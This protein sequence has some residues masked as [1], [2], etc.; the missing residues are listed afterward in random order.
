[1][2]RFLLSC[3][4][5]F[6]ASCLV[7]VICDKSN[8]IKPSYC[9]FN[10]AQDALDSLSD[11]SLAVIHAANHTRVKFWAKQHG[12]KSTKHGNYKE[13][14]IDYLLGHLLWGVNINRLTRSQI[15]AEF[16]KHSAPDTQ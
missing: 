15:T 16:A 8:T 6:F 12:W 4:D 11:L 10:S 2:I 5:I 3:I 13:A 7:I 14:A 1:M 9:S